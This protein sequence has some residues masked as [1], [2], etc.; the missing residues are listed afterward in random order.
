MFFTSAKACATSPMTCHYLH[1]KTPPLLT[2]IKHVKAVADSQ[3]ARKKMWKH[4]MEIT[5]WRC[6]A[7]VSGPSGSFCAVAH[8]QHR[9][10]LHHL[11]IRPR[12]VEALSACSQKSSLDFDARDCH[13]DRRFLDIYQH[14]WY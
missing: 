6:D 5:L 2:L 9:Y 4:S 7:N 13:Y 10:C 12:R 3:P 8:N 14:R 1:C 11:E